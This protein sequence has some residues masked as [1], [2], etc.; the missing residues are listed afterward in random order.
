MPSLITQL[1]PHLLSQFFNMLLPTTATLATVLAVASASPVAPVE[2]RGSLISNL[3]NIVE[4]LITIPIVI[5]Q[6]VSKNTVL[7]VQGVTVKVTNA[8]T[9]LHTTVQKTTTKSSTST[10]ASSQTV[11]GNGKSTQTISTTLTTSSTASPTSASA[12]S[13]SAGSASSNSLS[14][15]DTSAAG[16]GLNT[17]LFTATSTY[18]QSSTVITTAITSSST[19]VS[20]TKAVAVSATSTV[21]AAV[22][23]Q[24]VG[25]YTD[26][27]TFISNGVNLGNWLEI[28]RS[29]NQYFWDSYVNG[30]EVTDEWT[31]CE[32]LG[33]QCGPVLE[34]HYSTY[35]TTET[36][37]K[38]ANVGVNFLRIPTTYAAWV[39]VPGSQLYHGSQQTHLRTICEYAIATYGMRVVVGLHSLPGGVNGLDIGEAA[40][41]DGWFFNQTN[42]DYSYQA[43]SAVLEFIEAS[44]NPWAY[45]VGVINEASDNPM[46]FAT[47]AGMTQNGTDWIVDYTKTVM[48]MISNSTTPEVPTM[49]QDCF[50]GEEHW[51]P[52]FDITD[53]LVIDT[54]IYYFAAAG[55]YSGYAVGAICG[56]ASA[57]PGDAKFPVFI[58]E[59]SLQTLYNNTYDNREELFNTQRYAWSHY[60]QGGAFWGAVFNGTDAVDGEGTQRD[61]WDYTGL[62]DANVIHTMTNQT[63]C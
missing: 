57:A 25:E 52:Y 7:S 51:S 6:Q 12:S 48:D 21:P 42:L 46:G 47:A 29:N 34:E 26:W 39:I 15:V 13:A 54:H 24:A 22:T 8:P 14:S 1:C 2:K 62:I 61:Y 4:E 33:D 23:S 44:A 5:D 56:Q 43:I 31:F 35:I 20:T 45:T 58:G 32:T 28:E 55:V 18:P 11:A 17:A 37:D 41:H 30:T 60:V 53:N 3:V 9:H 36:I 63:Y 27:T 40:G 10:K 59:W 49:L 19:G 38:L 50:L 16:M